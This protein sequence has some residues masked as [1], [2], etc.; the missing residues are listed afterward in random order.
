MAEI[1]TAKLISCVPTGI[2]KLFEMLN[3]V[4]GWLK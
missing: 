2:M 4:E 1:E 3:E